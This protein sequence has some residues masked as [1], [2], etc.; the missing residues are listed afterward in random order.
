MVNGI[1][2]LAVTNLDGLD[3]VETV[4]VLRCVSTRQDAL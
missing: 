4:K 2:D 3:T 1:D